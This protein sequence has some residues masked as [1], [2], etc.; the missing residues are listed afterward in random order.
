[1]ATL[2]QTAPP[3]SP[4]YQRNTNTTATANRLQHIIRKKIASLEIS[5]NS[6]H[7]VKDTPI[8]GRV[9]RRCNACLELH[10]VP[11]GDG[12]ASPRRVVPPLVWIEILD[13][14]PC[15]LY[16]FSSQEESETRARGK[17]GR[18]A[19][20]HHATQAKK[21]KENN[22]IIWWYD[23]VGMPSIGSGFMWYDSTLEN[24]RNGSACG[25]RAL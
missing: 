18:Q 24:K 5:L 25:W 9:A 7:D 13:L 19:G 8:R 20:R 22:T 6:L 21:K 10:V 14:F 3:T 15:N 12:H 23:T 2:P 17:A 11:R 1:M 4:I 16:F